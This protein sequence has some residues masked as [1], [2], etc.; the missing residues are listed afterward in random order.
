MGSK[1]AAS[2]GVL[3]VFAS[4]LRLSG[5]PSAPHP[6]AQG[7]TFGRTRHHPLLPP[8]KCAYVCGCGVLYARVGIIGS[9]ASCDAGKRQQ[10]L[11]FSTC[12]VE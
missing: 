6:G 5:R 10:S 11:I 3:G 8:V 9:S 7:C 1:R 4:C 12:L 2:V